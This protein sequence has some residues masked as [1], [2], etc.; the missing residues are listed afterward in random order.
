M[1][2]KS[3]RKLQTGNFATTIGVLIIVVVFGLAMGLALFVQ[4][5]QHGKQ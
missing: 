4:N 1:M 2:P 5:E 3:V